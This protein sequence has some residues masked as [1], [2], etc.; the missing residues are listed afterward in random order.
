MQHKDKS[1]YLAAK[2]AYWQRFLKTLQI[3]IHPNERILDAGCGPAGI[4]IILNEYSVDAI[5]PLLDYYERLPH[6]NK[7]DYPNVQFYNKSLERVDNQG[8]YNIIFCL[9]AINHVADLSKSLDNLVGMLASNGRL[10][11]SIDVHKNNFLKHI[12]RLIPG[13]ILHPH[14]HGVADY[15]QML[16]Q[17]GCKIE[18]TICLKQ[19]RIFDYYAIIIKKR[20]T[21]DKNQTLI[22]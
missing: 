1:E 9:N 22:Y 10:I 19:G 18:K 17:R 8:Y 3:D 6:F 4:F 2:K 20:N 11:I 5:D 13:D 15:L 12:F 16:E 21:D 14:Q 7:R